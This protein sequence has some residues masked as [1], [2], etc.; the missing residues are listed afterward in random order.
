MGCM[1][2]C[3][4]ASVPQQDRF[5]VLTEHEP[6]ELIYEPAYLGIN[7]SDDI[8]IIQITL[9]QRTQQV[10]L[11]LYQSIAEKLAKNPGVKPQDMF[12]SLVSV[13]PEDWSFGDG[14]AQYVKAAET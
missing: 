6:A 2:C 14:K 8:V 3:K 4:A 12:I 11:A 1:R 10:K 13:T 9:N 5:Q 7:R